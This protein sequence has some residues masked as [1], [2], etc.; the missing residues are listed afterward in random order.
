MV[1][2]KAREPTVGGGDADAV[3]VAAAHDVPARGRQLDAL[4]LAGGPRGD[5]DRHD[6][7]SGRD[8]AGEGPH[9]VAVVYVRRAELREQTVVLGPG[10]GGVER[11][12]GPARVPALVDDGGE[13][14]SPQRRG[15]DLG[16]V[17]RG[18]RRYPK[19]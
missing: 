14:G 16:F 10:E 12:D 8:P 2:R 3:R 18:H 11:H 17:R 19:P 13:G 6:V 1:E 5:D 7:G 9:S 15:D 4:G